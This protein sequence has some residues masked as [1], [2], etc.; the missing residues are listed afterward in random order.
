MGGCFHGKIRAV[1][2][3]HHCRMAWVF[4]SLS[5]EEQAAWVPGKRL[6]VRWDDAESLPDAMIGDELVEVVG[7]YSAAKMRDRHAP[8]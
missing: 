1:D 4:A 5:E 7:R 8:G 3:A 2:A 6:G